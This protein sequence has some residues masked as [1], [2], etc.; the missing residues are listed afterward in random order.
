MVVH[1]EGR[2]GEGGEEGE[3]GRGGRY[4]VKGE[5]EGGGGKTK[6]REEGSVDACT[7]SH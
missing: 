7:V 4:E 1:L 3:E 6:W 2:G 5:K